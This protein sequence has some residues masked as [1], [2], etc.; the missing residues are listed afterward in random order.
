MALQNKIM[1]NNQILGPL[2]KLD[3][4]I[5]LLYSAIHIYIYIF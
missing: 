2:L 1:K 5:E 3:T 4:I